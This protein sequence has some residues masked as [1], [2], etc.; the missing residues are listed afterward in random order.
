MPPNRLATSGGQCRRCSTVPR[1]P[2]DAAVIVAGR[3]GPS[4]HAT[5]VLCPRC[6]LS[7]QRLASLEPNGA[8]CISQCLTMAINLRHVFSR[9]PLTEITPLSGNISPLCIQNELVL[10]RFVR[11]VSKQPCKPPF[12]NTPRG[13]LATKGCYFCP[14]L[15]NHALLEDLATLFTL[16]A[17]PRHRYSPYQTVV[18]CHPPP[19]PLFWS[20]SLAVRRSFRTLRCLA[21]IAVPAP[22]APLSWFLC[23]GWSEKRSAVFCWGSLKP[24]LLR[25]C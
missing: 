5:S 10:A 12:G 19:Q 11:R 15:L 16:P 22:C 13:D 6:H 24:L 14:E 20:F 17:L 25:C 1:F 8:Q 2:A 9:R 21:A 23:Y 4:I 3:R 18:S 7:E